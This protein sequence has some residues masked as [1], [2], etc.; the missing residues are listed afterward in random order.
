M[1]TSFLA[2]GSCVNIPKWAEMMSLLLS[3][4]SIMTNISALCPQL[5]Q[6]FIGCTGMLILLIKLQSYVLYCI[7]YIMPVFV[8][9]KEIM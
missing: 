6:L 1:K 7:L 2:N 9:E 8:L 3:K 5:S 4:H